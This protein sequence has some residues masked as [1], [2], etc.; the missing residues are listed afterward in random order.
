MATPGFYWP[1]SAEWQTPVPRQVFHGGKKKAVD[2]LLDALKNWKVGRLAKSRTTI[3]A[4]GHSLLGWETRRVKSVTIMRTKKCG[5][6]ETI[7]GPSSFFI[8]PTKR[9][10]VVLPVVRQ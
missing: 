7:G 1:R 4:R 2:A 10:R 6:A 3:K 5:G 8:D 9:G